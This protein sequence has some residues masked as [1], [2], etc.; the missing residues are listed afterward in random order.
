MQF[1]KCV[2]LP[3]PYKLVLTFHTSHFCHSHQF[4]KKQ[5]CP[6]SAIAS[7]EKNHANIRLNTSMLSPQFPEKCAL[8]HS[9]SSLCLGDQALS[10][11][12]S[13]ADLFHLQRPRWWILFKF[14]LTGGKIWTDE[15]EVPHGAT[16]MSLN[17]GYTYFSYYSSF[18]MQEAGVPVPNTN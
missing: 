4:C 12:S 10:G 15:S 13:F 7:L 3:R 2:A 8:T 11:G 18:A 16:R 6:Q 1:S 5:S 14:K 9:L 17:Y